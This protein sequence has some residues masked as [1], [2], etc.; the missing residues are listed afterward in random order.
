MD[1]AVDYRADHWQ[2]FYL[3]QGPTMQSGFTGQTML[4]K[5]SRKAW[6]IPGLPRSAP[7]QSPSNMRDGE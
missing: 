3:A 5:T 4:T 2:S 1:R 6:V 7:W